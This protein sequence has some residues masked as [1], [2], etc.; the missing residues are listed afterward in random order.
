ML[1]QLRP[2][3]VLLVAL[4][5]ITGLAYP[6]AVTGLA[7]AIFPGKAAGSPVERDGRIVGSALIGQSFTGPGWLHGRPSATDPAYNAGSSTGSNLGPSSTALLAQVKERAAAFGPGPVPSEMATAS[8]SGLDPHVTLE[9][10]LRQVPRIAQER[11]MDPAG[12]RSTSWAVTPC[13]AEIADRTASTM[14]MRNHRR[15]SSLP[16][17]SSV[18]RLVAR[19]RKCCRM[20]KPCAP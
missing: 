6:L 20:P 19:E 8:G 14:R 15:F 16:P 17:Y 4:T 5:A 9:A 1:N 3:L 12:T 2:A 7:G 18:R 11:G 13:R 10:A